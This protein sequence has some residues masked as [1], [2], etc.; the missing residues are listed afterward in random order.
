MESTR[1][2]PELDREHLL[3]TTSELIELAREL[4]PE[5]SRFELEQAA[6][7]LSEDRLNL[8]V[9]GK[10]KRGKSTLINALLERDLL[11]AGV[12]PLT[13]IIT[14]VRYGERERLFVRFADSSESEHPLGEIDA[15]VTEAENPGN[16]RGVEIAIVELPHPLLEHGLQ[17][18]DTPGL[19]SVHVHNTETARRFFPQIDAALVVLTAEQPLSGDEQ[20]LLVELA[21]RTPKL[22]YAV[23]KVDVLA[24]G[25]QEI[26]LDFIRSRLVGADANG[27]PE[28]FAVS[29][30]HSTGIAPLRDRLERFIASERHE[31]LLES[32]AFLA[33]S[34][35]GDAAQ[36]A[37]FEA[38]A[39]EL[40][41]EE[42]ESRLASF[43]E[44]LAALQAAREEARLLLERAVEDIVQASV[45]EPLLGYA[46]RHAT[47]LESSL[48]ERTAEISDGTGKL[49]LALRDAV[50]E[51][52]RSDSLRL[53]S[54]LES[55][56]AN[57]LE[58]A[59]R[60][61]GSRMRGILGEIAEAAEQAFGSRPPLQLPTL[62]LHTPTR[63]TF[64][65]R[66]E[67]QA[68][69]QLVDFG[70]KLVPGALGR[71]LAFREAKRHLRELLDRHAGRFRFDLAERIRA[72]A[73]DHRDELE[74]ALEQAIEAIRSAL[75]RAELEQRSG[76]LKVEER[77]AELSARAERL[78]EIAGALGRRRP[79]SSD[80]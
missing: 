57:A 15:F 69:E 49:S 78:D 25:E 4:T 37:R 80:A 65:L 74:P 75:G 6:K 64:K 71:R 31:T 5:R 26:A 60:R 12:V 2:L 63:F 29:A 76:R 45:N 58:Q 39:L 43:E 48:E 46:A 11:P 51:I 62:D 3:A 61:Y 13:S 73:G 18:V 1:D 22:F 53:A 17:L 23:N 38:H 14:L 30:R 20:R 21:E 54:E 27:S 19:G 66:D 42:L 67:A 8:V 10:F 70:Q 52:I 28:L 55:E 77:L 56:I 40:P 33:G 50:E 41:L 9:V 24:P 72:S 34:F 35:A 79:A 32:V 68:L 59:E 36:A 7:R 47:A 16:E 44:S